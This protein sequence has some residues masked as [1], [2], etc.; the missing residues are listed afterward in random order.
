MEPNNRQFTDLV[1]QLNHEAN[2][3]YLDEIQPEDLLTES[4]PQIPVERNSGYKDRL[5]DFEQYQYY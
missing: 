1:D 5:T 4:H 2:M 3:G